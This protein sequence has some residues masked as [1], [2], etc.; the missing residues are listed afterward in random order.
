MYTKK[1]SSRSKPVEKGQGLVEYALILMLAGLVVFAV[2]NLLNGQIENTFRRFVNQ[3][4]VAP[5]ALMAYTPPPT[6]TPTAGPGTATATLP[7]SSTPTQTNTPTATNT[8]APTATSTPTSTRDMGY[9]EYRYVRVI[10]ESEVNGNAFASMAEMAVMDG[11]S[12]Y[13][14]RTNWSVHYVSSQETDTPASNV[15]DGNNNTIWHTEWRNTVPSH[16]HDLQIDMGGLYSLSYFQYLPRQSGTNGRIAKYRFCASVNGTSWE[17]L[18]SGTFLNSATQQASL[19]TTPE[20]GDTLPNCPLSVA[21]TATATNTPLPTATATNTPLPTATATNTPLPTATNTP[22]ATATSIPN[23]SSCTLALNKPAVS[24]SVENSNYPASKAVDG[25]LS[26]RWSSSYNDNNW[27]YVDLGASYN[28]TQVI[29]RWEAAYGRDYD[30]QVS[31]DASTWTTIQSI[32]N[33]NGGTDTMSNLTGKGR[34]VRML[35]RARGTQYGYSLYEF[36]I[37]G[38]PNNQVTLIDANFNSNENGFTYKSG[39]FAASGLNNAGAHDATYGNNS[40]GLRVNLGDKKNGG[41]RSGGWQSPSFTLTSASVVTVKFDYRLENTNL[42]TGEC[43]QVL[44]KIE[45]ASNQVVASK[46]VQ[47]CTTSNIAWTTDNFDTTTLSTGSYTITLG[48]HLTN[49]NR[50]DE[51][52]R[53]YIDNVLVKTK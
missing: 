16:P 5:P 40:G 36:E 6:L 39:A 27:I 37:C 29:L 12:N 1:K 17:L 4:P 25:N 11:Y 15:F 48:G 21:P 42:D 46:V 30:I 32:N 28:I 10:A 31:D 24:S 35:G 18:A 45:N 51:R 47:S 53:I 26:S 38:T 41:A 13:I 2:V 49:T 3:A 7:P 9:R 34:Y 22:T 52:A 20:D 50:D 44:V 8:G 19:F 14:D 43:S 33:G 23:G